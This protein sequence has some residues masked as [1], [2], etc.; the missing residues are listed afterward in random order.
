MEKSGALEE[1][2][3]PDSSMMG[4]GSSSPKRQK[5]PGGNVK[6]GQAEAKKKKESEQYAAAKKLVTGSCLHCECVNWFWT[7]PTQSL[8][9]ES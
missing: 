5:V 8:K 6:P 7:G 4:N 3:D 2:S 9:G 1:D